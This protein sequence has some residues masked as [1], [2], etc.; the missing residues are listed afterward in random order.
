[1][2]CLYPLKLSHSTVVCGQCMNCRINHKLKWMGRLVLEARHTSSYT[3]VTLTYAE[4]HMPP[5]GSLSPADL[6]F[7]LN[8]WRRL[9]GPGARFFAVGEYG[10]LSFRPHYH[11][12]LFGVKYDEQMQERID[13]CWTRG[14]TH[15]GWSKGE[16]PINEKSALAYALGY[17]TK[18]MT[19][20]DDDRLDGR[21]P[22]FFRC[23]RYPTLG[24]QG[25]IEIG[26]LMSTRS[27]AALIAN[28]GWPRG[29][30]VEGQWFPYFPKDREQA[31]ERAGYGITQAELT[32]DT[33]NEGQWDLDVMQLQRKAEEQ[34]W[35]PGK[36]R[37][38]LIELRTEHDEKAEERQRLRARLKAEKARRQRTNFARKARD[39]QNHP[40][41]R[42][43]RPHLSVV[44]TG[45]QE[46]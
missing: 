9:Y 19:A 14:E 7:F 20:T 28:H 1:M 25:F 3:F 23:S 27:G 11:L 41:S 10:D 21:Q 29:F 40:S 36:L 15:L 26:D 35:S 24:H 42:D 44:E 6:K 32:E 8:K 37:E 46:G 33:K 43:R 38:K 16:K 2:L 17:V 4:E 39:L 30:K 18:K 34:N 13:Y 22:E 12:I 31:M 45:A 5:D